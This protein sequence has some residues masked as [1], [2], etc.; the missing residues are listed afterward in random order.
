VLQS[1]EHA[2]FEG[3][4]RDYV[5]QV[6][7]GTVC[8]YVTLSDGRRQIIDFAYAGDLIGLGATNEHMLSAQAITLAKLRSLPASSLHEA[9][10][11]DPQL[12]QQLY[13]AVSDQLCAAHNLLLTIGRRSA[14]ERLATLL[15][16]LSRRNERTGADP[17]R[18]TLPMNRADIADFLCLTIE[19]VSRTFTKLRQSGTIELHQSSVAVIRDRQALE[20]MCAE[21]A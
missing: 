8:L 21:E 6:E 3:D 10:R 19:T 20:R 7:K 13:R 17:L 12:S 15:M 4:A 18:I 9:A 14:T 2:F 11:H 1:R 16:T 5:Y